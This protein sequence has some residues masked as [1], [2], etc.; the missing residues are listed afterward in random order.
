[1]KWLMGEMVDSVLGEKCIARS[2]DVSNAWF[3]SKL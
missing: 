3:G 1:M 2:P